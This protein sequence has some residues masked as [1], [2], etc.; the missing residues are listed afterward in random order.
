M[1]LVVIVVLAADQDL[2]LAYLNRG[3]VKFVVP[4]ERPPRKLGGRRTILA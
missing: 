1:P 3:A 2:P 4:G